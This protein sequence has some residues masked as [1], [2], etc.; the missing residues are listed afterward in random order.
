MIQKPQ[1]LP[2]GTIVEGTNGTRY[3]IEDL[4]GVG[5][6]SAVYRIQ[7][8]RTKK[9]FAFKEIFNAY[10]R[11]RRHLLSEAELLRRQRH[12]ALPEVHQVFED[13]VSN[14]VYIL[15]DY[16]EGKDLETLR[17]ARPERHFS[18]AMTLTLMAPIVDAIAYLHCRQPPIVHRD[19]KPANI[20]VPDDDGGM[21]RLVD[22]GLAKEYIENKTT[23]AFRYGTPGY[24]APE[25]YGQ[26]TN[27]RTDIYALGASFYTLL[28]GVVPPDALIRSLNRDRTDPLRLADQINRTI[29]G[30]VA[31]V[32]ERSMRLHHEER[33]A[34]V[35]A[36]WQALK[37]AAPHSLAEPHQLFTTP[38][39]TPTPPV[40]KPVILSSAKDDSSTTPPLAPSSNERAT[41]RLVATVSILKGL[42]PIL[43]V[44]ILSGATIGGELVYRAWAAHRSIQSGPARPRNLITPTSEA[45]S[46]E[47]PAGAFTPSAASSPCLSS[48]LIQPDL[49]AASSYP[50]LEPCYLGTVYDV[51]AKTKTTL[52]L[53]N[54]QQKQQHI[55]GDFLGLNYVGSFQGT[56]T[57][58]GEV[59]FEIPLP[60]LH[61]TLS[62]QGTIK[63][64][65]DITGSFEAFENTTS[66]STGEY[67]TWYLCTPKNAACYE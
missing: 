41:A 58:G 45:H 33:F 12:P 36:F 55:Q 57:R 42:F 21:S 28:T 43:L 63:L 16:I 18:L 40:T 38:P 46:T 61:I 6:F 60:D 67:G 13:T 65:G 64:G 9:V 48:S 53:T 54:I 3:V 62:F 32:L 14:R 25:Q 11:D 52:A 47:S 4:L 15:M 17:R 29:P 5:G 35:E 49:A 59:T 31:A 30:S 24:A 50:P 7:E 2:G 26:G 51:M 27:P 8:Q 39:V 10:D 19:I 66:Q 56:V 23:S 1:T 22:F 44:V 20:L 37:A 34:S